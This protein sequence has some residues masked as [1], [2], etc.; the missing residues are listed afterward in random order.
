M[1]S[2]NNTFQPPAEP[3]VRRTTETRVDIPTDTTSPT[4]PIRFFRRLIPSPPNTG[5]FT[6]AEQVALKPISGLLDDLPELPP[7][8]KL[9][10]SI[11]A[12]IAEF[13][14]LTILMDV[15]TIF[16]RLAGVNKPLAPGFVNNL[17]KLDTP[18]LIKMTTEVTI[19]VLAIIS[20]FLP[21]LAINVAEK[22]KNMTHHQQEPINTPNPQQP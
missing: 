9:T 16:I 7:I 5:F 11:S 12:K 15:A 19:G 13:T 3:E 1:A 4:A 17:T 10:T 2:Q 18:L 14:A 8:L 6:L 22:Y 21:Y 20:I